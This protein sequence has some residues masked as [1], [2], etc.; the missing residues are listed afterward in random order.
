MK[1]SPKR[2]IAN[3]CKDCIY[4]AH[5][6]G[7]WREQV[8]AC[9]ITTCDLHDHRPLTAKTT[10]LLRENLLASLPADERAI[11]LERALKRSKSMAEMH[12]KGML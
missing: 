6:S 11:V 9:V 12:S 1:T 2:A 10:A 3:H 8:E 5:C 4:D 7:N